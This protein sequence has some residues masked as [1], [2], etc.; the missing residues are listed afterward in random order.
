MGNEYFKS[1][2]AGFIAGNILAMIL[3]QWIYLE[4]RVNVNLVIPL[5]AISGI[6]VYHFSRIKFKLKIIF[7]LELIFG[8]LVC[9]LYNFSI[10]SYSII[11]ASILR[12]GFLLTSLSLGEVNVIILLIFVIANFVLL[13]NLKWPSHTLPGN[14]DNTMIE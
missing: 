1:F 3:N 10:E 9:L 11:P 12:E 13:K 4:M 8:L 2:F 14:I 5:S 7:A 6:A